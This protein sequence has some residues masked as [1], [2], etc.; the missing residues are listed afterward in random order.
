MGRFRRARYGRRYQALATVVGLRKGRTEAIERP[1]VPPVADSIIEQTLP[2]L[3]PVI[4]DMVRL[5]RLCG[6]LLGE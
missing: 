1:P 5:Q 6:A 4:S 2:H 3:P